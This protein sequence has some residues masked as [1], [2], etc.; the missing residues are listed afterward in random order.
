MLPT[1]VFNGGY[2]ILPSITRYTQEM[3]IFKFKGRASSVS[4]VPAKRTI[5]VAFG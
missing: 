1:S 3:L 5:D 2:I 4:N